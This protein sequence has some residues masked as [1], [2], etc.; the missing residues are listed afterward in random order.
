MLLF[1]DFCSNKCFFSQFSAFKIKEIILW[2][3]ES[4]VC[5]YMDRISSDKR[6]ALN[7]CRTLINATPLG[8]HIEISAS[9]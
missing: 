4:Y 5:R 9:L 7:K 6:R 8:I 1:C 3:N 2:N